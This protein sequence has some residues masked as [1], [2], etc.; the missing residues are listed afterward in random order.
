MKNFFIYYSILFWIAVLTGCNHFSNKNQKKIVMDSNKKDNP[1]YSL[2]D[3]NKILVNN[4]QWQK[5]LPDDIYNIAREKGTERAFSGKYWDHKEVGAYYCA[6]C[7]NPLFTSNGK[8]ESNCGW[9]S[10][11]EPV[12]K[13]SIIYAPDNSAGM[14]RTEVM[15]GRCKAHLGHVFED[16]PPPTGLRYCINSV[17]LDFKMAKDSEALFNKKD[18]LK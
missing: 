16:G 5:I 17:I 14:K 13:G 10:F 12:T 18:G 3:S 11:F 8:F 7:G 9:P 1:Y 6:A 4:E 2:T 15:C